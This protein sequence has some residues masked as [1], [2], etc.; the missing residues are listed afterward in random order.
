MPK[1]FALLLSLVCLL[2]SWFLDEI[3]LTV[4]FAVSFMALLYV[5]IQDGIKSQKRKKRTYFIYY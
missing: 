1:Y 3:I 4:T 5:A 2:S